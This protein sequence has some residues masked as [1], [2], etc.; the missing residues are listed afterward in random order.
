MI[1][2]RTDY[3]SQLSPI[4]YE[5]KKLFR[6][7]NTLV[8][9]EIGAC[10]GEDSIR[11]SRLFPQSQIYAFEPLPKNF[12]LITKNIEK[13]NVKNVEVFNKALSEK[14]DSAEFY[15]SNGTP[16][17]MTV[18]DWDFGNKSS[19]LLPPEEHT[20]IVEFIKFEEKIWVQT[21]TLKSF[22]QQSEIDGIDF[23]HMDV[24]GAELLVLKGADNLISNIKVI[25][26][27]VAKISLYKGQPLV[28]DI[29][30]F[31][32]AHDFYLAKSCVDN[33][34]GDQLYISKKYF[35]DYKTI[36]KMPKPKTWSLLH[37]LNRLGVFKL[38]KRVKN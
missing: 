24:Q 6:Q 11:Y 2:D 36:L 22:C 34:S 32:S 18:S 17:G 5:L 14:N 33:I 25:W 3:I 8:I 15:V 1:F 23:I 16:K 10:E 31:M 35:P 29:E 30:E 13:Y 38:I 26:L 7:T 9:F 4:D 27:E 21:I 12:E 28:N 20:N 37:F 19:S